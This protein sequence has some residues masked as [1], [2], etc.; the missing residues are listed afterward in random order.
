MQ[1]ILGLAWRL[2][3]SNWS[4]VA[5]T[6]EAGVSHP[7]SMS[8]TVRFLSCVQRQPQRTER[9]KQRTEIPTASYSAT[10]DWIWVVMTPI[11][12]KS[13]IRGGYI[14]LNFA[15]QLDNLWG[16]SFSLF[17]VV[18]PAKGISCSAWRNL[19]SNNYEGI[20]MRLN[21]LR[22]YVSWNRINSEDYSE[23]SL[24]KSSNLPSCYLNCRI[25]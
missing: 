7:C 20:G 12:D 13:Y 9:T 8:A 2:Q 24:E 17:T 11:H 14:L 19:Y 10:S 23:F 1:S 5:M 15:M 3:R 4:D 6:S 18:A 16:Y 22:Y 21:Y 25:R